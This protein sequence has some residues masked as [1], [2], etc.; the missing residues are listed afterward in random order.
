MNNLIEDSKTIQSNATTDNLALRN[1]VC[2]KVLIP[3]SFL[4]SFQM[5]LNLKLIPMLD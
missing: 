4:S 5:L 1:E 3:S 2:N